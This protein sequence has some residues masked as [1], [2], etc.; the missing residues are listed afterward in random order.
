MKPYL[1]Y[2][3]ALYL[4]PLLYGLEG[5][6]SQFGRVVDIPASIALNM[7][8]AD[9]AGS[10][11]ETPEVS[12]TSGVSKNGCAFLSPLDYARH[13]AEYCIVPNVAVSS[14][15][16]TDTVQLFVKSDI[17][18]I[19][20]MAVDIR[21][22]SEIILAKIILM[23]KYPNE[24]SQQGSLQIIPMMPDV[25]A[26]LTRADAALLVN[27]SPTTPSSDAFKLDLVEE[28]ADLTDLPYVHGFWVGKEN[29]MLVDDAER[30]MRARAEGAAHVETIAEQAAAR[31]GIS[32]KQA[33]SYLSSFTFDFGEQQSDSLK[34]FMSY[35]FYFGI[36]PDIPEINFFD[37]GDAPKLSRN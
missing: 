19:T 32:A 23:E 36:L 37:V 27:L 6:D 3:E 35:A 34:E 11:G 1:A 22:T 30:L 28:W 15:L 4:K 25:N 8:R 31:S 9:L 17:R 20:T 21:V 10:H 16:P 7:S 12:K 18:N 33:K 14:S 2:P 13:G 29:Q 5:N 26:M 24:Q